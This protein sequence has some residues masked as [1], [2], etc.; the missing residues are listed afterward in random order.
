MELGVDEGCLWTS[1]AEHVTDGLEGLTDA[2]HVN[3]QRVAIM[4]SSAL[5]ARI[6]HLQAVSLG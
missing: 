2:Q 4:P 5:Q 3:G 6:S 1:M